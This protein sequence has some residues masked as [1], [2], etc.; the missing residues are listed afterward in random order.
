MELDTSSKKEQRKF[1]LVMAAAIIIIGLIRWGLHGGALPWRF[2]YVAAAFL[3][4]G[5]ILPRLLQ[6]VLIVWLKFGLAMNWVMTRV[7]LTLAFFLM[8]VPV[9]VILRLTGHDPLNR[10]WKSLPTCSDRL[11]LK[12]KAYSSR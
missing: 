3:A 2:F 6:P 4:L 12:R 11:R 9:R 8:I 1:G 5:I 7:L 10:R